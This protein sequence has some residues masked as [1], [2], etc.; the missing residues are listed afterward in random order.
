MSDDNK[1]ITPPHCAASKKAATDGAKQ[2]P[3]GPEFWFLK[4][5]MNGKGPFGGIN[6][7]AIH[8]HSIH[9]DPSNNFDEPT[10][11][12]RDDD[13]LRAIVADYGFTIK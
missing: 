9:S 11:P 3:S 7:E 10:A 13:W 12:Q 8:N 2:P 4:Y 6:A 5:A 1:K